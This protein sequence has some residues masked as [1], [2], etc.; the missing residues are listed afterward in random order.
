MGPGRST[1]EPKTVKT[2]GEGARMGG[3]G[4]GTGN[5]RDLKVIRDQRSVNWSDQ[6]PKVS[7][8]E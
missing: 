6:G 5:G 7:K 8:T 4:D 2:R 3:S 1:E